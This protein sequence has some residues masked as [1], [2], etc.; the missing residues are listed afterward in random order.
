MSMS[1][2]TNKA[3]LVVALLPLFATVG[4]GGSTSQ[5]ISRIDGGFF[6]WPNGISMAT[7]VLGFSPI[8][9]ALTGGNWDVSAY[10]S[11][12]YLLELRYEISVPENYE[13]SFTR[14]GLY[15]PG[16]LSSLN[17]AGNSVTAI[18]F[19]GFG[20]EDSPSVSLY[21]D[22]FPGGTKWGVATYVISPGL[23]EDTFILQTTCGGVEEKVAR[24]TISETN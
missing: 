21:E 8:D 6:I 16:S 24:Q 1:L 17:G 14:T 10:E 3:T 18:D 12:S 13:R 7:T 4:C 11:G 19:I 22:I 9:Q 5:E 2:A 23:S 15:C 20:E